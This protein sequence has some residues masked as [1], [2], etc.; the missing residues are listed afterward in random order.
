MEKS[1]PLSDWKLFDPGCVVRDPCLVASGDGCQEGWRGDSF[2]DVACNISACG[3]DNTAENIKNKKEG[4]CE[5]E[6]DPCILAGCPTEWLSDGMCDAPCNIEACGIG[7]FDGG[8]CACTNKECHPSWLNDGECDDV[9]K[10]VE[11]AYDGG[12]CPQPKLVCFDQ[13]AGAL[14][15]YGDGCASYHLDISWCGEYDSDTFNS[16]EMCCACGGGKMELEAP[17]VDGC[18]N[19]C[20]LARN[21]QC[22]D[23]GDG[24]INSEC[25]IGTDCH[26]CGKRIS[27]LNTCDWN[28]DTFC[29]DGGDGE[30]QYCELGTDCADCGSRPELD[31]ECTKHN[32]C[33][34]DLYCAKGLF[35]NGNHYQRCDPTSI[36]GS[37]EC[38][39][40]G[41]GIGGVCP[42]WTHSDCSGEYCSQDLTCVELGLCSEHLDAIDGECPPPARTTMEDCECRQEWTLSEEK[43]TD[44]CC[45]PDGSDGDWCFTVAE[46]CGVT[47]DYAGK[48]WGMCK[49]TGMCTGNTDISEDVD[50]ADG[51]HK[52]SAQAGTDAATC[53]EAPP[54]RT[55]TDDCECKKSWTDTRDDSECT[56]YCCNPDG[57]DSDW[58]FT[59]EDC[60]GSN[61]GYCKVTG[62]CT[63]NTD[64]SEDV[65]CAGGD[66]T[67][68]ANTQN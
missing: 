57:S 27:C 50:C 18:F 41:D 1:Y 32:D 51:Q 61:W 38:G 29:D 53:C 26:D 3:W 66:G 23:G 55:T 13:D 25:E 6:T 31:F 46:D 30:E 47:E 36:D 44:Y 10:N 20:S 12:D 7:G 63:G 68:E 67:H 21:G 62:M 11:C 33:G 45:N 59:V 22:N 5:P 15:T 9:C 40:Y 52:G 28:G 17:G 19:E 64:R 56:D 65:D 24:S 48:N 4:D 43:C 8:D 14:D 49:V 54:A 16:I 39:T 34:V 35:T 42:C 37:D 2:C 60:G 58:C